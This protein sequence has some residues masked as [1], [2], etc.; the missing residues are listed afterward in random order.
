MQKDVDMTNK[1]QGKVAI[2][3]GSGSP[4]GIGKETALAMALEGASVVINDIGKDAEGKYGA[5]KVV[6]AIKDAGGK[7]AANYDSI[8]TMEGGRNLVKTAIDN[9]GK[10]DILVNT[11]GNYKV[12]P[13][14]DMK[15]S[16]WDSIIAVHLK[17]V[18]SCTQAALKYMI[19]QKSGR[20]INI[21][22]SASWMPNMEH[23]PPQA[24]YSAG[25]AGVMGFTKMLSAE[26]KP[27]NIT[28]NA[29]SP[30]A[31]TSLFPMPGKVVD[32][33]QIVGPDYV[34][35]LICYLSTD[36]AKDITGQIFHMGSGDIIA[37]SPIML[38]PGEH[39]QLDKLGDT[40]W[41]QEELSD[42]V[43][44]CWWG[45]KPSLL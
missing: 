38:S 17:G 33:V 8:T 15:E 31:R 1:L 41:T 40:K 23:N 12:A 29:L 3:T 4:S 2:I 6:K 30:K 28:V 26:M 25:K 16:D 18:F 42:T 20:I 9:F 13:T 10:I 21:T 22:S 35:P 24:A 39:Q 19:K 37:F 44:F 5:D 34:A 7:A 27:Y 11:A 14:V 32:G 43:P 36:D 45:R